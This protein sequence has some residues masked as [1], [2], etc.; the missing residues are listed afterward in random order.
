M[1]FISFLILIAMAV[2]TSMFISQWLCAVTGIAYNHILP[3]S[4]IGFVLLLNPITKALKQPEPR[5]ILVEPPDNKLVGKQTRGCYGCCN[6]PRQQSHCQL[7][8]SRYFIYEVL[9]GGTMKFSAKY[10]LARNIMQPL[11]QMVIRNTVTSNT[12]S[13]KF[14]AHFES[15]NPCFL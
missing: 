3:F 15:T 6:L 4:I 1:K 14:Q 11:A 10:L 12:S 2:V 9:C 13:T 5:E 8:S 7:H